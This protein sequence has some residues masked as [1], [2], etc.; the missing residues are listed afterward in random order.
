MTF[1]VSSVNKFIQK[2]IK[3]TAL[4]KQNINYGKSYVDIAI[5]T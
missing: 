2:R 5:E 3:M 1:F 4:V